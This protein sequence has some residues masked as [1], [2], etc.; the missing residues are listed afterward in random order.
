[1][2]AM[3]QVSSV[4]KLLAVVSMLVFNKA[5]VADTVMEGSFA[6]NIHFFSDPD[7]QAPNDGSVSSILGQPDGVWN[8]LNH[9]GITLGFS[10][11]PVAFDWETEI[12]AG[13]QMIVTDVGEIDF[14]T[15]IQFG[16]GTPHNNGGGVG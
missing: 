12:P 10:D 1:M 3:K 15:F 5:V 16:Y 8:D 11:S 14:R 9:G 4:V 13:T 6:G 2:K 7:P